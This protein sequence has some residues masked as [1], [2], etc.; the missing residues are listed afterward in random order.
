M[1]PDLY[2]PP[3]QR[4][5]HQHRQIPD[6][7]QT[8]HA[9][10]RQACPADEVEAVRAQRAAAAQFHARAWPKKVLCLLWACRVEQLAVGAH[11]GSAR[12]SVHEPEHGRTRQ[13]VA[14]VCNRVEQREV[15]AAHGG[16]RHA[17]EE[18]AERGEG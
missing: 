6:V 17:V 15:G 13:N 7:N 8:N 9:S 14:H 12:E 2:A 3:I 1:S 4:Q 10:Q 11:A 5:S 16:V 18:A